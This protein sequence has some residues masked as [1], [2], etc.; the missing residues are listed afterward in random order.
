MTHENYNSSTGLKK[1]LL[2]LFSKQP[3]VIKGQKGVY[4]YAIHMDAMTEHHHS[5]KYVVS[6][7]VIAKE[8]F[9]GLVEI[10]I[11]EVNIENLNIFED[12]ENKKTD[13]ITKNIP[14]YINPKFIKWEII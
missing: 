6:A 10:E 2:N 5:H 1:L 8:V 9:D 12:P 7:K 4:Q 13:I 14:K 3:K 11:T